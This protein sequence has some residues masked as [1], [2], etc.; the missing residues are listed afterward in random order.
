MV[1]RTMITQDSQ[2]AGPVTEAPALGGSRR[3]VVVQPRQ[4][5]NE[6]EHITD[7]RTQAIWK[8][9]LTSNPSEA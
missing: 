6:Y 5:G 7:P 2:P 3:T 4:F 9:L 8:A 1:K